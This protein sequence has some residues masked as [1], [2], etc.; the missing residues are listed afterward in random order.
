[1]RQWMQYVLLPDRLL[2]SVLICLYATEPPLLKVVKVRVAR[3]CLF[4][5]GLS[6]Q[7]RTFHAFFLPTSYGAVESGCEEKL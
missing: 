1:M 6:E 5:C 2:P 3:Y 4:L 7:I